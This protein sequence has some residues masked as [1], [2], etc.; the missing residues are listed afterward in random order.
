ML[1]FTKS[2]SGV[3]ALALLTAAAVSA[4]DKLSAQDR[5][6]MMDA[7]KGGMMEVHMGKMGLDKGS[8]S[9]VKALSQR[10]IDDHSKGNDELMALA[11]QKGV[12]LPAD[13]PS[14]PSRLTSL[15]GADFDREFAKMAVSDHEKDIAEFEKEAS[16][17]TNGDVKAWASKTLPVLRAHLEAARA[18]SGSSSN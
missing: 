17:G 8:S 13:G 4:Q 18:L 16:S 6:F 5:K 3:A 12:T 15:S 2:L 14:M 9:G 11:K 1:N 7:A 10:L